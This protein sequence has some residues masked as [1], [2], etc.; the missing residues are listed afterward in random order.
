MTQAKDQSRNARG[1]KLLD[2]LD[3]ENGR[4]MVAQLGD[5]GKYVV[6]FGFGDIYSRP[7]LSLRDREMCAVAMLIAMGGHEQQVRFHLGAAMNVGLSSAEL[8]EVI[9]QT[10]PFAGFPSAMNALALLKEV[11]TE[12]LEKG[13]QSDAVGDTPNFLGVRHVGLL[14]RDPETVAGFYR[15]VM[16]MTLVRQTAADHG[17][18]GTAFLGRHPEVE[19]HDVVLVANEKAA[20]TAFRVASLSDLLAFYQRLKQ[21]GIAV[22]NCFDHGISLAVYFEDPEG[23]LLEVYWMTGLKS[24]EARAD[25]IDLGQSEEQLRSQIE[26]SG[27]RQLA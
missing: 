23:H 16:G 1:L 13:L 4:E 9:I 15:D 21:R 24:S 27:S 12:R 19:D 18:G 17:L 8:E 2:S 26:R 6:D 10:V 14:A 22:Q 3:G 11:N 5:V 20:H 7:G 25:P